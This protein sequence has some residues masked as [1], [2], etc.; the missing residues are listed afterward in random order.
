M[1]NAVIASTG[2]YVPDW[3]LPNSYFNSLLG[4][5]VDSFLRD[6]LQ[7]YERRWCLDS[8]STADICVKA[9]QQAM[10]RAGI[11]PH[12]L[13]LI[14]VATDT[15]EY[16]SP[17]TASVVQ[18]RL[19][20]GWAGTFDLNSACAGFTTAL[21]VG[22]KFI[23][24]DTR[25][26]YVMVIGASVFSRYLNKSDK[27][28]VTLFADGAGAVLLKAE[29]DSNR[30]YL[31]SELITLGQYYDGMGIYG[32][33]TR[34]PTSHNSID[35]K[36]HLL[37]VHYRFPPELNPQMWTHMAKNLSQLTEV[38][39]QDVDHYI[40]TQ[41]NIR[42]IHKTL[43]NLKVPLERAHTSMHY[44]GY[45]AAASIPIALDDAIKQGK[46]NSNDLIYFIGSGGGLTFGSVAMRY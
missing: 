22:S 45:T 43:K 28:T 6:K 25:Y 7:I 9:A 11:K 37:K 36:D 12:Q 10:L 5:D 35:N 13:N 17:S 39:P 21:D 2:A 34:I 19:D 8:E 30:G 42:S 4:E 44:Y 40:L 3:V 16:M 33:G 27:R 41:I 46:I 24:T 14:I 23:R 26:G 31:A 38:K 1:R 29:E 32:G 18:F 15:P 20:A